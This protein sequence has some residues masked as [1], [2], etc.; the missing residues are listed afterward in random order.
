[1]DISWKLGDT[2][3]LTVWGEDLEQAVSGLRALA[4]DLKQGWLEEGHGLYH[5]EKVVSTVL[6]AGPVGV[7]EPSSLYT[8]LEAGGTGTSNTSFPLV[9]PAFDR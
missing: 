2:L 1:M 7:C 3:P 6:P 4:N 8:L 5:P 9:V